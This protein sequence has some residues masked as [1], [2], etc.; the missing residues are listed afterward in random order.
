VNTRSGGEGL[1]PA[2][3]PAFSKRKSLLAHFWQPLD[4]KLLNIPLGLIINF[5]E[6]GLVDGI[7]RMILPAANL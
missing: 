6:E 2:S 4:M 5:H 1:L 7:V 3:P